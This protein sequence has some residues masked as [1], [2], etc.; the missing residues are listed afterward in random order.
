MIHNARVSKLIGTSTNR[1][2]NKPTEQ[3]GGSIDD[4]FR[5]DDEQPSL[6][7]RSS[8]SAA[9]P[10]PDFSGGGVDDKDTFR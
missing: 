7:K 10:G 1:A 8:A 5:T 2:N 4:L 3:D 6:K 9:A